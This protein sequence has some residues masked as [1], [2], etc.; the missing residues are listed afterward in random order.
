MIEK[1]PST[2][3]TLLDKTLWGFIALFLAGTV[4]RILAGNEPF[5]TRRFAGEIL[6]GVVAAFI[7]YAFGILQGLTTPQFIILGGTG[8]LG[9]VRLLEW[10]IRLAK[11]IKQHG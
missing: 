8:G 1:D 6:L 11:Q 10:G 7:L 3:L 2:T 4:G 9:G 5:D